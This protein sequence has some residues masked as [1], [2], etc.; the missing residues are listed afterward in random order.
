[1]AMA[2]VAVT[3]FRNPRRSAALVGGLLLLVCA[4]APALEGWTITPS[5]ELREIYTDNV[6]LEPSDRAQSELVTAISPGISLFRKG[7]RLELSI[8]YLMENFLYAKDSDQNQI[9]HQLKSAARAELIKDEVF[10]DATA[11]MRQLLISPEGR[12]GLDNLSLGDNRTDAL[13]YQVSPWW[14][15]DFGG[16]VESEARYTYKVTR[17]DDAVSDSEGH[18]ATLRL[19]SGRRYS[20]L[21]WELSHTTDQIDRDSVGDSTRQSTRGQ[22][23]YQLTREWSLLAEAGYEDNELATGFVNE[24]GAFWGVGVGWRPSRFMEF[25]VLGGGN[26][27]RAAVTL[28][29]TNRSSLQLNYQDREVGLN[30]GES[31]SGRLFHRTRY[32]T[33]SASYLETVTSVQELIVSSVDD[34]L[35]RDTGAPSPGFGEDVLPIPD[36]GGDGLNNDGL[37]TLTDQE[38]LRKR[39]D[40][41]VGYRR[42][43][44]S[45]SVG[46]FSERREFQDD[47]DNEDGFGARAS[48][49]WRFATRTS[50][51]LESSWERIDAQ[52]DK[53]N[54]WITVLGLEHVFAEDMVGEV[55]YRHARNSAEDAIDGYRENRLSLQLRITF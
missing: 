6:D 12:L 32:S 4:K 38:F 31:W 46:V 49:I 23:I 43:R 15:H 2:T 27:R 44:S 33:W 36:P 29:P 7:R 21:F 14:R 52:S 3:D 9:N 53:D 50:S 10:L 35:D 20:R 54:L 40:F 17:F 41:N 13:S 1:M 48:W 39:F 11:N 22:G 26:F 8:N 47:Q 30:T 42:G 24:D 16:F 19:N 51:I 5:I 18:A 45:F 25:S 34:V 55:R 28:T 37:F